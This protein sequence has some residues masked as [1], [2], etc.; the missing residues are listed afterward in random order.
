M[1]VRTAVI[2]AAG[3]GTRFLPATKA[4]PKELLPIVDRPTIQYIVEECARAGLS[5]VLLV[6][7]QGKSAIEDHFDVALGLEQALR[8][9]GKDDLLAE[10]QH[11]TDLATVHSIRQGE[12]LGLGHA[13]L[14]A[15]THVGD[16][17]SFVVAL[18]DDIVDPDSDFLQRMIAEHESTGRAVVA[19][20]EVPESD[21]SK[22]GI[23]VTEPT[24]TDGVVRITG[25]VEKPDPADAPSN[26]AIIGRYVLPGAIFPVLADTPPGAGGEIQVTDALHTMAQ[27]APIVGVV[28]DAVRHDAGDKLGFLQATVDF[29]TRREDLG[30]EFLDWLQQFVED[31]RS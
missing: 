15:R 18:G 21:V 23:A 19:L 22:Y 14:Q 1:P 26:L 30:E 24:D 9:K 7:A 4:V 5:D 31:R 25:L 2:P 16:D 6:T 27:D 17:A 13:I 10:V 12:A 20:M 28:L 11:A 8:D 3:F 29:A